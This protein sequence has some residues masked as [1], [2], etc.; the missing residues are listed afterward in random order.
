MAYDGATNKWSYVAGTTFSTGDLY[1]GMIVNSSGHVI[2]PGSTVVDET[3]I[4]TLYSNTATTAGAGVEAVTVALGPVVKV[5]M[6]ASTLSA[7]NTVAFSTAGLGI[8][9]TT[10]NPQWGIIEHGSSGAINRIVTVVRT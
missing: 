1:K 6:A 4:G 9:P 10:D 2:V 8:A 3:V 5:R 7:G